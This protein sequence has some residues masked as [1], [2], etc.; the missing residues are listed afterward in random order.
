MGTSGVDVGRN[1][2]LDRVFASQGNAE[3]VVRRCH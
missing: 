2:D 3:P 1:S